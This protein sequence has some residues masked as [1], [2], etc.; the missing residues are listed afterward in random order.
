MILLHAYFH[1]QLGTPAAGTSLYRSSGSD[2]ALTM[3]Q[4][5]GDIPRHFPL[6]ASDALTTSPAALARPCT[7]DVLFFRAARRFK[8]QIFLSIDVPP[9]L[10]SLGQEG[11]LLLAVERAVVDVLK[12]NE[13]QDGA[14]GS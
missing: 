4:R 13:T 5:L 9:S 10:G 11:K 2:T 1:L 3:A 8:K 7:R 6:H 12:S 14:A